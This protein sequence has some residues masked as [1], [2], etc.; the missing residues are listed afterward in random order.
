M[1]KLLTH[2]VLSDIT[3]F[4]K[5]L[6]WAGDKKK[7][8]KKDW[9]PISCKSSFSDFYLTF[10]WFCIQNKF[11]HNM[12]LSRIKVGYKIN[13][14]YSVFIHHLK[15]PNVLSVCNW[16]QFII[17]GFKRQ[18]CM[19]RGVRIPFHSFNLVR[20]VWPRRGKLVIG[21]DTWQWE[22]KE[23]DRPSR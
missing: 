1:Y 2:E 4:R 14:V 8:W 20:S 5:Y 22:G 16:S 15:L 13:H 18:D 6:W 10:L 12:S 7:Y 17:F 23:N 19:S 3:W 11:Y 9:Q 21:G